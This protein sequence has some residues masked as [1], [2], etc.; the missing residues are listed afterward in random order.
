M[1]R[2][3]VLLCA[4]L[5]SWAPLSAHEVRPAYLEI[6][7]T[8]EHR[9]QIIWKQPVLGDI[10]L[11]LVP[12]LSNGWLDGEATAVASDPAHLVRRWDIRTASA[13]HDALD[14]VHVTVD[15]LQNSITDVLLRVV[16]LDGT[17][18]ETILK[19]DAP[20]AT[21]A[22]AATGGLPVPAYFL[23]GVDHIL[24]GVDH[25][26]FVLGLLLLIGLRWSLLKAI[27]AFTVAHS[28]TLAASALG[29]VH[30]PS[31]PIEAL[32]ALS[33][34]FLAVELVRTRQRRDGLAQ[35]HPWIVA[36]AFG[37][38]H[39]F[40]F[41]GALSETGLPQNAIPMAL[42]LFNL[43]VEAGQI[44]FVAVVAAVMLGARRFTDRLPPA[45]R[46]LG[47]LAPRYLLGSFAAFWL[48]ER[49]TV[50]FS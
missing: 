7:Q 4:L 3:L 24:T 50:M 23:L 35:Q 28:I 6:A 46:Q 8:G 22:F 25:L 20:T 15:G 10:A 42:L 49:T 38:L 34:L 2:L 45:A 5:A 30:A 44:V 16:R 43:G 17:S 39:G 11:R 14:N 47:H 36:F 12:R 21:V 31:A 37:L 19:P 26:C 9:Y 27:T 1:I 32:V 29:L 41:A 33:I 13:R 18:F 40:A 48:F